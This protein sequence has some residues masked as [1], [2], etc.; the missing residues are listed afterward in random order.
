MQFIW[1]MKVPLRICVQESDDDIRQQL[2][3]DLKKDNRFQIIHFCKSF[4]QWKNELTVSQTDVIIVN[5]NFN[6][7][8]LFDFI[9]TVQSK[10]TGAKILI[11]FDFIQPD[12]VYESL[13]FGATGFLLKPFTTD[14]IFNI[15]TKKSF[16]IKSKWLALHVS[17]LMN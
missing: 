3:R 13:K 2:V 5:W 12:F 14:E 9:Q 17:R 11:S 1:K 6:H 15:L 4:G 7:P 10:N 8:Q 16:V